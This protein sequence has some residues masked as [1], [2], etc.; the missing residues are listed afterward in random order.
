MT[1]TSDPRDAYIAQNTLRGHAKLSGKAMEDVKFFAQ[2]AKE[3]R[4]ISFQ[5]MVD[6]L[7]DKHGITV[8]RGRLYTLAVA[9]GIEPWW[10]P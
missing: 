5:A 2:R 4:P 6:W 3:G 8:G 10:R 1:K 9:N 7:H